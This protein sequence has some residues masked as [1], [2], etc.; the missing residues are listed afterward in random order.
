VSGTSHGVLKNSSLGPAVITLCRLVHH[1]LQVDVDMSPTDSD[2]GKGC[3]GGKQ[4]RSANTINRYPTYRPHAPSSRMGLS[5]KKV[6][7]LMVSVA[8]F[9]IFHDLAGPTVLA[10]SLTISVHDLKGA[11]LMHIVS[12]CIVDLKTASLY[13]AL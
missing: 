11:A 7:L 1:V 10:T 5:S 2:P 8:S 12:P 3:A 6:L 4:F 9:A 13:A